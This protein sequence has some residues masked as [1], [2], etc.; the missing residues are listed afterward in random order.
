[1]DCIVHGVKRVRHHPVTFTHFTYSFT[2]K[3][4]QKIPSLWAAFT[5]AEFQF[6]RPQMALYGALSTEIGGECIKGYI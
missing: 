6:S 1:M 3:G 4:L 2:L 5:S